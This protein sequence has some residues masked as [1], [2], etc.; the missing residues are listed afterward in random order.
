VKVFDA[1][2][3]PND[4]PPYIVFEY[5]E[6]HDV[7]ELI[8]NHSL[9]TFEVWTMAKQV[10]EGL[11]HLHGHDVFHCDIKPQ[12]L[13][14]KDGTVRIIDFNVSV[15]AED[16]NHGGGSRK[17]LPPDLQV[18]HQPQISDLI[19]RDLYALGI[20]LYRAITGQYP[21]AESQYPQPGVEGRNPT[22]FNRSLY[23]SDEVCSLLLK[24]IAPK[25]A[26]R[27]DST[28][29]LLTAISHIKQLNKPAPK[30]DESTLQFSLPRLADGSLPS[31][32]AF[33][34]YLLT[35]YSQS[36][37]SNSGTRGLDD[38]SKLIY[39]DT[40]L[41]TKLAPAVLAGELKLVVITG[42]A[43]DGK[44]AFLQQL[45]LEAKKRGIAVNSN[46]EG[47]GAN[48]ELNG[49]C[50]ISNYDGS[51]D[52]GDTNNDQVL[53]RFF[54]PFV[55]DDDS[56]WPQHETRLIAINEGRLVDFMAS[57]G[58]K[59]LALRSLL[60][61]G[62]KDGKVQSQVAVVNLNL[63]DVLA[64]DDN[65]S[66][67]ERLLAR[68]VDKKVW[69]GCDFCTLKDKCYVRYNVTTLQDKQS[70]SNVIQRLKYLYSLTNLR[71][72]LHITLRDLRSALAYTLVGGNSCA[73]IHEL[74]A[75]DKAEE[76]LQGYYFNAWC[77]NG[78][79]EDRLLR[80][81]NELDIAESG[82]VRLDR[83]LDFLGPETV[84]W[85]PFEDRGNYAM[86]LLQK[87]HSELPTETSL[88]S[89][90]NRYE[91][92][93]AFVGMLRRK[94]FF[95]LRGDDWI[96]M[97]AYRSAMK[98]LE[99]LKPDADLEKAK[100]DIIL[101]INRGEGL[102]T[103]DVFDGQL[104]M[105]VR[106]I[107]RG[108]IKSYRVF[109]ADVFSI[110]IDHVAEDASFIERRPSRL[111]LNYQGQGGLHAELDLNLDLFELLDRLNEGYIP[112]IEE[113]QGYFLSLTVFKNVLASAPYQEVLLTTNGRQYQTISR[114]E[115]GTLVLEQV[116]RAQA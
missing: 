76:I 97:P 37:H 63:R 11:A 116:E 19:D 56:V 81:L 93:Q 31:K 20:T 57:H 114:E 80:L 98:L 113:M 36:R 79:S 52:E 72:S 51:Q 16:L 1:D 102:Y 28:E 66:I 82:N 94:V 85:L 25:R 111:Y 67:F 78:E 61:N 2:V 75:A 49:H 77:G 53:E 70:A 54:A 12:N 100:K 101:A 105:Q 5:L 8:S 103:P 60:D 14:W 95:E 33:H 24:M 71:N 74:Y 18:I 55:G 62:L 27:F 34:D 68:M 112:S 6:G 90:A 88:S 39:V 7:S 69:Q 15:E 91:S 43:G 110:A 92:H 44:T 41:D 65:D 99:L 47:N 42:N 89:G 84:D 115:D 26:D 58:E 86:Q 59:Y 13:I 50:F 83:G 9:T 104:A 3:L 22:E 45:E 109:P 106:K 4:G 30:Q 46:P 40:A 96:E 48:F 38:Y 23:L 87:M 32:N 29:E 35:L 64:G 73:E 107:E 10:A 108:S 17:Y 21:W